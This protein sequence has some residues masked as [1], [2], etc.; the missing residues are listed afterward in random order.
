MKRLG[1]AGLFFTIFGGP[2][3]WPT[4]AVLLAAL[5]TSD[6]GVPLLDPA[7]FEGAFDGSLE[8]T[9]FEGAF[10]GSLEGLEALESAGDD[11]RA[12]SIGGAASSGS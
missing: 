3:A 4:L 11:I 6:A 12:V 2:L 8:P 9:L 7:L 10:E 1:A 5:D